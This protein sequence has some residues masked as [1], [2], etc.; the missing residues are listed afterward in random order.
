MSLT[1]DINIPEKALG[2]YEQKLRFFSV[3][4]QS[5]L[6]EGED[7]RQ[8]KQLAQQRAEQQAQRVRC[9]CRVHQTVK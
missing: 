1:K 5:V 2:I 6:R 4:G 9:G 8:Q 7:E 3:D